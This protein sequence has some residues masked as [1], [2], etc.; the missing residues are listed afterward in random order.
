VY[1]FE[2]NFHGNVVV[3]AVNKSTSTDYHITALK[4][5]MPAGAYH[6][7]LRGL[8][9]GTARLTLNVG[10][11][12]AVKPF[13]L[14]KN[15]VA[16]W[17]YL[18]TEPSIPKIGNVGPK[19]THAGDELVING[20]GF[21]DRPGSVRIGSVKASV[22]RWQRHSVTVTVPRIVGARY[23]VTIC[24][25]GVRP[26]CTHPFPILIDNGRQIPVTFTVHD[27]PTT[28]PS[29]QTY[30]SGSVSELGNWSSNPTKAVGPMMD[31]NH[32]AWFLMVSVPAC[33]KISFKFLI[34]HA[35]GTSSWEE[36]RNHQYTVPCAGTGTADYGWQR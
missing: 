10:Q 27:V 5:A 13:T 25:D 31:P 20:V 26:A 30:V 17:Q 18:T 28:S 36:G 9:T 33:R 15:Q 21:G 6:D 1:V 12:G 4:T 3:V 29:D 19:L 16:V 14:G 24:R 34:V 35:D 32:P 11:N 7:Y 23:G 2:R 8:L 22:T